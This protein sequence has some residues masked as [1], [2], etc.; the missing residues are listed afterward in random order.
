[1]SQVSDYDI[2]N[3]S[4]AQVRA[5]I[6]LVLDAIKSVNSGSGDP[7]GAVAFMLY[8]D[9]SDNILKVRNSAN[10]S[11]TEIGNINEANLGLMPITG[12]T[13]MTGPIK[14]PQGSQSSPSLQFSSDTDTGIHNSSQNQ[15]DFTCGGI[16]RMFL[17]NDGLSILSVSGNVKGLFFKDADGS[18]HASL[19]APDVMNSNVD[20]RLPASIVNGGFLKTDANGS[21]SFE[22]IAGVPVATVFCRAASVV[23]SGYLECNGAAISRTT[24]SALFGIIGVQYGTG[25]G[26]STFNLPDLRGEFIRGF[27]NGRGIDSGRSMASFQDQDNRSH[28]HGYQNSTITVSGANHKHNIRKIELGQNNNGTVGRVGITL[29]SGQSYQVGYAAHDNGLEGDVIKF[30][31]NQTMTGTAPNIDVD[32]STTRPRNIAMMYIIKT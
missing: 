16:R 13:A 32:G 5:D 15:I 6:N 21:L 19:R 17:N 31:G 9:T 22:T 2:A 10:S 20:L 7:T 18:P 30:S 28:S 1:M 25:N 14:L 4:G 27:D 26:S 12:S 11:F 8:G 3:A 24:Y 29:G 23:P